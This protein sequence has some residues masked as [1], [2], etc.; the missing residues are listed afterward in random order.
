MPVTSEMLLKVCEPQ[1]AQA[2]AI[3][4]DG[5][6]VSVSR[7]QRN[8]RIGWNSARVLCQLAVDQG[9]VAGLP[10]SPHLTA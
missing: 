9:K 6:A 5:G 1:V 2:V 3:C 7:V 8:M 4:H 10:L